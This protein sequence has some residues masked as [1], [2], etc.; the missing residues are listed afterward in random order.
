[1]SATYVSWFCLMVNNQSCLKISIDLTWVNEDLGG[2]EGLAAPHPGEARLQAT[3]SP[4][5]MRWR[6]NDD[7]AN[8][9]CRVA[10]ARTNDEMKTPRRHGNDETMKKKSLM[11]TPRWPAHDASQF[12]LRHLHLLDDVTLAFLILYALVVEGLKLRL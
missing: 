3:P 6:M 7:D 4:P 9:E 10:T 11:I 1:M 5:K 8:D 2:E 12:V